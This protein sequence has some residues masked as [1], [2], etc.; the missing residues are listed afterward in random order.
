MISK[1]KYTAELIKTY[2]AQNKIS[3]T[4]LSGLLGFSGKQ[5]QLV[6]NIE[7]GKCQLPTDKIL[8]PSKALGIPREQ[9]IKNMVLDY[10]LNIYKRIKEVENEL[11]NSN[12]D[13][14]R[15]EA[16]NGSSLQEF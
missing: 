13:Q 5:E 9:I 6:S 10:E 12:E 16:F 14:A 2:R 1:A 15:G 7:M 11:Q 8:L 3:Q 4:K